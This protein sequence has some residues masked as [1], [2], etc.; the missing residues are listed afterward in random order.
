LH[1]LPPSSARE[2]RYLFSWRS[3]SLCFIDRKYACHNSVADL[4]ACSVPA[5]SESANPSALAEEFPFGL[6]ASL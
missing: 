5:F 2:Y 3:P 6:S 1:Y 4:V